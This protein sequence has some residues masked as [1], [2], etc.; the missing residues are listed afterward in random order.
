M[1]RPPSI[2]ITAQRPRQISQP[3]INTPQ[4]LTISLLHLILA[5]VKSSA[6]KAM[7][8]SYLQAQKK[9]VRVTLDL[10]VYNDF[11]ARQIDWRKLF[12]LDGDETVE[13]YVEELD[14]EW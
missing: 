1:S 4:V 13:A 7:S 11:N 8:V 10:S 2:T 5:T 9:N 14:V 12:Q 3:L 6:P